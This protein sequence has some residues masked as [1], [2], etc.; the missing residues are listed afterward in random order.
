MP[1]RPATAACR[2]WPCRC[3][4]APRSVRP[5]PRRRAR[6]AA[7][8]SADRSIS[9]IAPLR[10]ARLGLVDDQRALPARHADVD[11]GQQPGVEQRAV[12]RAVGVVDLQ[13]LAQRVERVALAGE[14]LARHQQAVGDL[15]RHCSATPGRPQRAQFLVRESRCRRPRCGSRS[16]RRPGRPAARRPRP[17]TAACR[18]GTRRSGRARAAR[19]RWLGRCGFR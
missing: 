3:R 1:D 14:H 12:Q 18:P 4:P 2:G 10:V 15:R 16:R 8:R 9:S 19:P 5:V 17:R 11:L 7:A 6:A 13:P